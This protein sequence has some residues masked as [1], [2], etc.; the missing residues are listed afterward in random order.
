MRPGWCLLVCGMLLP[1]AVEAQLAPLGIPHGLIRIDV[2]GSFAYANERYNDGTL[3]SLG[4]NFNSP[5]LGADIIPGVADADQRLA[6]LLNDPAYKLNLGAS[7]GTGQVSTGTGALGI[8]LG[9]TKG[10][11]LFGRVP[12]VRTTYRQSVAIDTAKSGAGLN[13][14]DPAL[15]AASAPGPAQAFFDNFNGAIGTLEANLASGLY[16]G[17]PTTRARAVQTIASGHALSD[18]LGALIIADGTASAFLPL[19]SSAAGQVLNGQ[20]LSIQQTMAGL[21]VQSF[22]DAIPLPATPATGADLATYATSPAGPIADSSLTSGSRTG[23]GDV[24]VG[25]VYTAIDKWDAHTAR[26]SRLAATLVVRIPT[27]TVA[28]PNDPFGATTGAG[29]VAVG[30][31]AAFDLGRGTF[32]ARFSANYLL[33]MSGAFTRRVGTM[34]TALIPSS[35]IAD[36][37]INPGDELQLAFTPFYRL[38][39]DFGLVGSATWITRGTD[40]VQYASPADSIPGVPASLLAEGT[41]ASRLLLSL[42]VTYAS[43]GQKADGTNGKPLD[44]GVRWETTVASSGGIVAKWSSLIFFVR[45]YGKLW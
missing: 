30:I 42:G 20:V 18:S 22:S 10:L 16:D 5:A 1:P 28:S 3:E 33:Q 23:I 27:G 38:A 25:A 32:G 43:S 15:G 35:Y 4:A 45:V 9:I 2:D 34:T 11:T 24:Q 26:G 14:A 13:L 21:G 8:G 40:D 36:V 19:F 37:N 44:A 31:G 17:D 41:G 6:V 29:T 12:I 39:P 7:V